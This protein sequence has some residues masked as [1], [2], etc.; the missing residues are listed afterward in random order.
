MKKRIFILFCLS[1]VITLVILFITDD[2]SFS[3]WAE[4][5][6]TTVTASDQQ[7]FIIKYNRTYFPKDYI[8]IS[9]MSSDNELL[10]HGS[11]R[12]S[13]ALFDVVQY[14]WDKIEYIK[15]INGIKFYKTPWC[16]VYGADDDLKGV[17]YSDYEDECSVSP[18]FAEFHT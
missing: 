17:L 3:N 5:Q 1:V 18:V 13:N 4:T 7:Q 10:I 8:S 12:D 11:F 16:I 6:S 14:K 15:S 9:L 2:E